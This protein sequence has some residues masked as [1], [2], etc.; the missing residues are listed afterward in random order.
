MRMERLRSAASHLRARA[1]N[2]LLHSPFHAV[3]LKIFP[4]VAQ[5]RDYRRWVRDEQARL[6][7]RDECQ[8]QIEQFRFQPLLSVVMP[9]YQP[10][11]GFLEEAV[12]SVRAQAY[13]SWQLVIC[14]DGSA[15]S[16]IGEYLNNLSLLDSRVTVLQNPRRLGIS[17][18]LNRCLSVAKGEYLGF[19]DHDDRLSPLALYSVVEQLQTARPGML[20]SDE[21]KLNELGERT[22]PIFK[23]GWSPDLLNNGMYVGH[24]LVASREAVAAVGGFRSE[25]DGSQDYD[26]ALRLADLPVRIEHI[27]R[28]L[29]HWRKHAG[30][31]SQH[32]SAKPYT[33]EAGKRALVEAVA[34]RGWNAEVADGKIP[35]T[36]LVRRR[37]AGNP[38][39]SLIVRGKKELSAPADDNLNVE[40][41]RLPGTADWNLA[42]SRATGE[43]LVFLEL[44]E[45]RSNSWLR[46]IVAHLQR[47][48]IGVVGGRIVAP[49][50]IIQHA[51]VALGRNGRILFPLRGEY[52]T[53]YWNWQ[54][55]THNVSAVSGGCVAT[56]TDVFHE[57]KGF[58]PDFS[59]PVADVDFCLRVRAAGYEVIYEPAALLR[60]EGRRD[61]SR[62]ELRRF[63]DRWKLDI[64]RGDPFYHSALSV[65][66][67]DARLP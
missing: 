64:E 46:E 15:E 47:S 44:V 10:P 5:D 33:H 65:D 25:C 49:S 31:T 38:K 35:N 50:G 24:F 63:E 51:G 53:R 12:E 61:S 40:I 11:L 27:P 54:D 8:R 36:H 20:Y 55:Y 29:Y 30:S 28:M 1:G 13:P 2:R 22:E 17:G 7:D 39:V 56:R 48:E 3:Y 4:L 18:A 52:Q 37:I 9:V 26:L 19:L 32:S 41:L 43:F 16:S 57:V 59:G 58:S 60:G 42:A 45:P 21:D 6:P 62:E 67:E 14:N 66:H 23:P 34:R